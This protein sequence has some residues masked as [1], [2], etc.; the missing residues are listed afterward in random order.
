VTVAYDWERWGH[1]VPAG[2]SNWSA[3]DPI[4]HAT[5]TAQFGQD[6]TDLDLGKFETVAPFDRGV[7]VSY[8]VYP[9]NPAFIIFDPEY[10]KVKD[11]AGRLN[12]Y[13]DYLLELKAHHKGVP[14]LIAE[15]GVPSS[16][17]VAPVNDLAYDHGGTTKRTKPS[18]PWICT[19]ASAIRVRPVPSCSSGSTSGSSARGCARRRCCRA[20][21][22]RSGTT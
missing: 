7:F 10:R 1:K 14:L 19:A 17:G 21:A 18:L 12:N 22:G 8:H 2:Y 20:T 13:F 15:F 6:V 5:E 3:L 11:K 9:F 4:P 16:F